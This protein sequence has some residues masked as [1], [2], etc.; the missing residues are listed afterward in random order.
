VRRRRSWTSMSMKRRRRRREE[1]M[2][3]ITSSMIMMRTRRRRRMMRRIIW[4]YMTGSSWV[5]GSIAGK[6]AGGDIAPGSWLYTQR[7]GRH[8]RLVAC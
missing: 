5:Q 7:Q 8:G 3:M 6:E 1:S 2:M 4:E